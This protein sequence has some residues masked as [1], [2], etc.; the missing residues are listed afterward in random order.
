PR[1]LGLDADEV[2]RRVREA[3]R[4]VG[5]GEEY[6]NRSPFDLSGGQKRRVAI[7]GVLAM[8]PRVL[9]LDE[10]TAGL[11]PAGRRQLMELIEGLHRRDG[12]TLI[13]VSHD[14]DE[15]ARLC[16]RVAV[17]E[18]GRLILEGPVR[19]VYREAERLRAAGLEVPAPARVVERLAERGW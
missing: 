7:A 13:L 18:K 16:D 8:E 1:N 6:L 15:V 17:L 11:D 19:S 2:N 5:L 10:P 3:L 14:M 4:R 9:I 12:L